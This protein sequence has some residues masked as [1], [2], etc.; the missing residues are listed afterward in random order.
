V[1]YD[2]FASKEALLQALL[3]DMYAQGE[4]EIAGQGL[5]CDDAEPGGAT[6]DDARTGQAK[7]G[8]A[9]A[10]YTT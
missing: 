6:D 1:F 4:T 5:G 2:H 9:K 8:Q 10:S 7:A 3:A